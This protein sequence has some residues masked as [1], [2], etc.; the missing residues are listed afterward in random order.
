[1][2]LL[3]S[4]LS[5]LTKEGKETAPFES[6]VGEVLEKWIEEETFSKVNVEAQINFLRLVVNLIKHQVRLSCFFLPTFPHFLSQVY[7]FIRRNEG[8]AYQKDLQHFKQC[9]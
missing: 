6:E 5:I 3:L 7:H 4:S 1:M 9:L 8:V 2:Q